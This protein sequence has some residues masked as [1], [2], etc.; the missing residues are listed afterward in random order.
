MLGLEVV[1]PDQ[2]DT[3]IQSPVQSGHCRSLR[4]CCAAAGP[5]LESCSLATLQPCSLAALHAPDCP[6]AGQW[7]DKPSAPR[8]FSFFINLM[9]FFSSLP[10]LLRAFSLPTSHSSWSNPARTKNNAP[11]LDPSH[12]KYTPPQPPVFFSSLAPRLTTPSVDTHYKPAQS[13]PS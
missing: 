8:M 7:T 9:L 4:V 5:G 12:T 1:T 10:L 3:T 2:I 11:S 6:A 13:R